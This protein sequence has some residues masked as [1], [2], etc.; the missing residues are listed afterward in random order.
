MVYLARVKRI[1]LLPDLISVI[2]LN[3][4]IKLDTWILS[5]LVSFVYEV[6]VLFWTR[7]AYFWRKKKKSS[8]F[9]S[10]FSI[11]INAA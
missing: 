6:L 7:F 1:C 4:V 5:Q 2:K 10:N 3:L 9:G 11:M 8:T